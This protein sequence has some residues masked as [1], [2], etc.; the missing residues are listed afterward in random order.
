MSQE[1]LKA[2]RKEELARAWISDMLTKAY[3]G[4]SE[5]NEDAAE[6]VLKRCS[7]GCAKSWL[8]FITR[9]Y[10]WDPEKSDLG[11]FLEAQEKFEKRLSGDTVTITREGNIITEA[12]APGYC[13]CPLVRAYKLVKPFPNLCLCAK[14][15]FKATYEAGAKRPVRV[16]VIESYCRGGNSCTLRIELL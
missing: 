9:N 5:L 11:A 3:L 10:G 12:F 8:S 6:T 7:E 1:E 4:V 16:E 15:T 14:N 2:T 13:T